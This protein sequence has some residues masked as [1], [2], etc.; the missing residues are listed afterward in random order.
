MRLFRTSRR[1]RQACSKSFGAVPVEVDVKRGNSN[2]TLRVSLSRDLVAEAIRYMLYQALSAS[3]IPLFIH[4]A[5]Q[6]NFVPL[7][8]AAIFYRQNLVATGSNGMYLSVTCAEDLPLI[9]P[10]EGERNGTNTFLGDYRLRQQRARLRAL[11]ARKNSRRLRSRPFRD[12]PVLIL[13]GQWDP[14]TPPIYGDTARSIFRTAFMS[15]CRTVA[16]AS[17]A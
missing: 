9:K 8:N 4:L 14:V 7:A 17:A 15:S 13:T 5:A 12:V 2:E 10:G 3:R 1:K 6:G 11:A 16:T